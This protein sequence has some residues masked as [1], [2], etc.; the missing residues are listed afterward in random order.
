[1]TTLSGLH[2]TVTEC[3]IQPR[4]EAVRRQCEIVVSSP[5]MV[6]THLN[7]VHTRPVTTRWVIRRGPADVLAA[8]T[9]IV[10]IG[11]ARLIIGYLTVALH[12]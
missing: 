12:G 11:A 7:G 8:R 5:M 4:D 2:A 6:R 3:L 10:L 9:A 1:M